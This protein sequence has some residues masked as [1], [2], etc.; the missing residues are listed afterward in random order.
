[1]PWTSRKSDQ[2]LVLFFRHNELLN[3][4]CVVLITTDNV[5]VVVEDVPVLKFEVGGVESDH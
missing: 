1:M 5:K 2:R 4:F 3:F